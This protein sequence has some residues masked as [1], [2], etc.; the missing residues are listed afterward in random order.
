MSRRWGSTAAWTTTPRP[1]HAWS[2]SVSDVV[3]CASLLDPAVRVVTPEELV[4]LVM[5]NLAPQLPTF[6]DNPTS[7]VVRVNGNVNFGSAA[8][9]TAP[10]SY[11]WSLNGST[12][13]GATS[14]NLSLIDVP[15][16]ES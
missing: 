16:G 6:T 14:Q 10:V 11:H 13:A 8:T 3:Q 4:N 2:M 1:V 7:Q 12:V 15:V 9:G 5:T